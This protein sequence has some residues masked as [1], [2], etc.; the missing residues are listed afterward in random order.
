[1]SVEL[2]GGT[3]LRNTRDAVG[4]ALL[5]ETGIAKGVR[6]VVGV[7]RELA[8]AAHAEATAMAERLAALQS[9]PLETADQIALLQTEYKLLRTH[10]DAATMPAAAKKRSRDA[11]DTF[12]AGPVKEALKKQ[13]AEKAAAAEKSFEAVAKQAAASSNFGVARVDFGS[14]TKLLVKM[15]KSI[16]S[17]VAPDASFCI[18]SADVAASKFTAYAMCSDAHVKKGLDAQD[19]LKEATAAAGGGKGGGK[20][21]MANMVVSSMDNIDAALA[22]AEKFAAL[23]LN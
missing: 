2:C 16:L 8:A 6:R 7:T 17:K 19:W 5:E 18:I 14:D 20:P 22:A 12:Q 1:M 3:H 4:F 23:K 21:K 13:A 9:M 15:Q 10:L 11:L